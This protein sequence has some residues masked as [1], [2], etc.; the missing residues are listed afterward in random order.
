MRLRHAYPVLRY[1]TLLDVTQLVAIKAASV[2]PSDLK[3]IAGTMEGNTL[4]RGPGPGLRWYGRRPSA[5]WEGAGVQGT[6]AIG[7]IRDGSDERVR[8]I[9]AWGNESRR[10]RR[11]IVVVLWK[12]SHLGGEVAG[13]HQCGPRSR[14]TAGSTR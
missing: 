10:R 11:G 14:W 9:L 4:L 7:F 2:N 3:D 1:T 8:R 5:T 12:S 13:V 6:G